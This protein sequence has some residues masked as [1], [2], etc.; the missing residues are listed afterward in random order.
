MGVRKSAGS[1]RLVGEP[2]SGLA[3]EIASHFAPFLGGEKLSALLGSDVRLRVHSHWQSRKFPSHLPA[4]A[5]GHP[6]FGQQPTSRSTFKC[7]RGARLHR[8]CTI[9]RALTPVNAFSRLWQ[10]WTTYRARDKKLALFCTRKES[11]P[12]PYGNT[13]AQA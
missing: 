7:I 10:E 3:P 11:N 2:L 6:A 9:S 12:I 1:S 8:K 13:L 5:D 4:T